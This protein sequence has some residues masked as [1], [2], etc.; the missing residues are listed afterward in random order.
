V[1]VTEKLEKELNEMC[2]LS[3][4]IVD[5]TV[6]KTTAKHVV[7]MYNKG[8]KLDA[9]ADLLEIPEDEVQAI[10]ETTPDTQEEA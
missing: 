6:A 4:G 9:I 1:P 5:K 10:L 3:Q 8:M 7:L 2:N